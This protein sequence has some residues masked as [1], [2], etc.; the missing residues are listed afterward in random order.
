MATDT[1]KRVAASRVQCAAVRSQERPVSVSTGDTLMA[2][3]L[4]HRNVQ[5]VGICLKMLCLLILT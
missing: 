5:S 2:V 3:P 4:M 1:I